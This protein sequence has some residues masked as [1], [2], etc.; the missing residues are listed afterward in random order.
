MEDN[1]WTFYFGK[2]EAFFNREE[3]VHVDVSDISDGEDSL[4]GVD[5]SQSTL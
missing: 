3:R 5:A 2:E 4:L 1:P